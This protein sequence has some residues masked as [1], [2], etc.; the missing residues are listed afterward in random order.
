MG[1]GTGR[2]WGRVERTDEDLGDDAT[3]HGDDGCRETH[4]RQG[5]LG[6]DLARFAGEEARVDGEDVSPRHASYLG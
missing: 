5:E 3:A 1:R 2:S 4:E 6:V